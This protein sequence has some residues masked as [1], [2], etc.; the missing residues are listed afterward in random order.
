MLACCG[1]LKDPLRLLL[2]PYLAKI[3]R[4]LKSFFKD[5]LDVE[6]ERFYVPVTVQ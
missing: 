6:L 4:I 5:V 3:E 1:N 2:S